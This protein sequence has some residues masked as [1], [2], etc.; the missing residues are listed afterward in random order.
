MP[1]DLASVEVDLG[2]ELDA[3]AA[4][5]RRLHVVQRPARLVPRGFISVVITLVPDY[6]IQR[7]QLIGGGLRQLNG[8]Q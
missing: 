5:V 7:N 1:G 8:R 6:N 3:V 4:H 2:L